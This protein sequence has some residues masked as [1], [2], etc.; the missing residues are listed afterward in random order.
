MPNSFANFYSGKKVLVTGHTGFKGGWLTAWLKLL[1]AKVIGLALP[2]D[3]QPN[4]FSAAGIGEQMS[5]KF[6]DIRELAV[7][8]ALFAEHQPEIVIHN[9]AQA[10]VRRSYREPVE[11]YATNVMGTVNV[12]EAA[13]HAKTVRAV[14]VVTSDKCYENIGAAHGYVE[15]DAMGGH[16]PYSSSKAAAELVTAAYRRSCFSNPQ[17]AA[18][19]SARA[20]NVI[21]GGDWAEDR[22][23][24]DIVRGIV[25]GKPVVIRRPQSVRPWQHVLEP[26]RGYL[27]LAQRL[28]EQGQRFA[29][30]WNFGPRAEDAITVAQLAQ[31]LISLW[32]SGGLEIQP[33]PAAPHEAETLRLDCEKSHKQI[34][35]TPALTLEQALDW[36]TDWYRAYQKDPRSAA[37]ITKSQIQEY[38]GIANA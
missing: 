26:V 11:T 1:G 7:V 8:S 32:G 4:L 14:V 21:G 5:S 2:P 22:L 3:T 16:D 29:E 27:R 13:R 17:G 35:W 30:P 24:P 37:A 18:V 23:V 38:A 25:S 19:A 36:T 33:D 28:C 15:T 34:G 12:L 6:G 9:A 10:L 31:K 20:G